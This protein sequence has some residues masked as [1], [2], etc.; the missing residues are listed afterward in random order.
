MQK[1]SYTDAELLTMQNKIIPK[2]KV[3]SLE[4]FYKLSTSSSKSIE[5]VNVKLETPT[6]AAD[7][8]EFIL[9]EKIAK[10]TGRIFF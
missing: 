1:L 5:G 9:D 7:E 8:N 2:D 6:P 4:Q 3:N 10:I